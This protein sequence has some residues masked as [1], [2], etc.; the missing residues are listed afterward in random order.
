MKKS[1]FKSHTITID[2]ASGSEKLLIDDKPIPFR[3]D[4]EGYSIYY[5]LGYS[6]LLAAAK[7]FLKTQS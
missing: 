5:N 7:A 2:D 6:T 1:K 4:D 3:K